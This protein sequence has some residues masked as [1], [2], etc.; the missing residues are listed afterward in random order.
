MGR[1]KWIDLRSHYVAGRYLAVGFLLIDTAHSS[2]CRKMYARM[3]CAV[4]DRIEW[5]SFTTV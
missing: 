5:H 1:F 3:D 4:D 2:S